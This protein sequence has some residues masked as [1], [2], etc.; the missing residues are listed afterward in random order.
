MKRVIA[1]IYLKRYGKRDELIDLFGK[2]IVE[3]L[4]LKG[5]ITQGTT[6]MDEGVYSRTWRKTSMT[7]EYFQLFIKPIKEANAENGKYLYA[8]GF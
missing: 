3:E 1:Y 5:Y 4:A 8:L 6:K 2:D 7:D